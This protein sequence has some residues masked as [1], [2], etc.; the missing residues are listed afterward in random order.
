MKK[1][2]PW[3]LKDIAKVK[4]LGKSMN[5]KSIGKLL[6][7]TTKSVQSMMLRHGLSMKS[8]REWTEDEDTV[9]RM[10][11]SEMTIAEVASAMGRKSD[12]IQWRARQLG[13]SFL[14]VGENHHAAKHSDETRQRYISLV[15]EGYA[16]LAAARMVDVHPATAHRWIRRRDKLALRASAPPPSQQDDSS[17]D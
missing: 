10:R 2:K 7:R 14:K 13:V 17:G 11:S 1:Q 4:E 3:T 5:A 8:L 6:N 16:K 12:A 9:I 15:D